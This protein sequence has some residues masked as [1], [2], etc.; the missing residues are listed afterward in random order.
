MKGLHVPCVK[1]IFLHF[2][3][4]RRIRLFFKLKKKRIQQQE[5]DRLK[6]K[7]TLYFR[8]E[9]YDVINVLYVTAAPTVYRSV[10]GGMVRPNV[11]RERDN[12]RP[13]CSVHDIALYKAK[14]LVHIL[15]ELTKKDKK[16]TE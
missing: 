2:Q 9:W 15:A 16:I 8:S 11:W 12:E 5:L 4:I 14:N 7:L 13:S 3:K 6:F 1:T 10:G